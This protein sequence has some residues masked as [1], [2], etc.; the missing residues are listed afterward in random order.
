MQIPKL[1]KIVLNMGIGEAVGDSKKVNAAIAEVTKEKPS[2]HWVEVLDGAGIPCGRIN[3]I[4]QVFE[5]PQALHRGLTVELA[6][7]DLAAPVR[8]VASPIR[9]SKTPV[10]YDSAPPRLGADTDEVLASLKA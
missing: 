3:T 2:L 7:D 6:R 4:D 10:R 8:T 5:E 9:L 1:D